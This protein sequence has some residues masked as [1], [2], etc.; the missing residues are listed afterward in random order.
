VGTTI[1]NVQTASWNWRSY[2]QLPPVD[3]DCPAPCAGVSWIQQYGISSPSISGQATEFRII[4]NDP[5]ADVL[6]TAGLIGQNSPQL[7]DADHALLPT[8]HN[9]TYDA[10][11]YVTDPG[12][13]QAVEF[14]VSVWMSDIAGMTFGHQCNHLGDGDWDVWDNVNAKWVSSG[15]PC[16]FVQGWNHVTIKVERQPDN[17]LLYQS[18]ALNGV[19]YTLNETSPSIP[20]PSGWWGVNINYQLDSNVSGDANTTYLDNLSITY[21]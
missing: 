10:Y 1:S 16:E 18:I 4:P 3:A 19:T 2:G 21:W 20:C 13:T 14:D 17:S 15:A 9:F 6:F 5:Y 7:P 8:V 11:F 12:I